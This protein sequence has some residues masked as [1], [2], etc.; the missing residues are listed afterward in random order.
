MSSSSAKSH[1]T[2]AKSATGLAIGLN[3]G[4]IVTRRKPREKP[5]RRK[6]KLGERVKNIRG[7]IREVVG[8]APYE[9][10]VMEI[11]RGGGNNPGKRAW[12]FAKK[13]LGTHVRAK[14]KVAE[15]NAVIE[16]LKKIEAQQKAAAAAAAKAKAE[17]AA[18]GK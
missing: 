14:R 6:G 16:N 1:S 10:R 9:K 3:K 4:F 15:M 5:S 11:L 13:R 18:A 7:V 12:R 17:A 2:A 8:Y